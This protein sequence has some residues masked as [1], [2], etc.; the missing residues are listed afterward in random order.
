M[1]YSNVKIRV[2]A[3]AICGRRLFIYLELGR[4]ESKIDTIE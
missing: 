3:A 4:S 1:L 2:W